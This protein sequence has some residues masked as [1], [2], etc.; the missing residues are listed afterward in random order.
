MYINK[1]LTALSLILFFSLVGSS[2]KKTDA[3][4]NIIEL[5]SQHKLNITYQDKSVEAVRGSYTWNI[6]NEDGSG[7]YI[8][9]DY[10]AAPELVKD[11]APLVVSPI[12][13]LVLNYTDKPENVTVIIWKDNKAIQQAI[14]DDKILISGLKGPIIYEVVSNCEHGTFHYA[15]LINV[16]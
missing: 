5:E 3:T 12:K 9:H 2:E 6:V 10:A 1:V 15:F 8:N 7:T 16:I 14:T 11:S 4:F 13:T